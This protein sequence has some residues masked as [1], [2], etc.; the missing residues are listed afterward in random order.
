MKNWAEI[1][2]ESQEPTLCTHSKQIWRPPTLYRYDIEQIRSPQVGYAYNP[3]PMKSRNVPIK[4]LI[5]TIQNRQT[6]PGRRPKPDRTP[7]FPDRAD[8]LG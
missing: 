7:N 5:G 6:T 4:C 2:I 1:K 3:D 8:F